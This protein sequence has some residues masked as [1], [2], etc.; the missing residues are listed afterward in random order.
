MILAQTV[1]RPSAPR[2]ASVTST[3]SIPNSADAVSWAGAGPRF[4]IVTNQDLRVRA[5]ISGAPT[6]GAMQLINHIQPVILALRRPSRLHPDG[7]AT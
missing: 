2:S 7:Y 4:S 5:R 3:P 1:S 6:R